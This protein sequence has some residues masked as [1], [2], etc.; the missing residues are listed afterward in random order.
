[1]RTSG[2]GV[3]EKK[4]KHLTLAFPPPW[5]EELPI[6]IYPEQLK[7]WHFKKGFPLYFFCLNNPP[8][9]HEKINS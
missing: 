3:L 7:S 4:C 6:G 9:V 2:G 5:F 1:M 8:C